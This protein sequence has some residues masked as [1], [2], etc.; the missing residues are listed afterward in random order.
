MSFGWSCSESCVGPPRKKFLFV[1]LLF[2]MFVVFAAP[3]APAK[4]AAKGAVCPA[5][6]QTVA[7]FSVL[8]GAHKK[9]VVRFARLFVCFV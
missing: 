1:F 3:P 8:F 4:T 9:E 6:G 7:S 5:C 2:L